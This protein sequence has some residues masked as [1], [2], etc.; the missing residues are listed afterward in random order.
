[1]VPPSSEVAI[2]LEE[3]QC[4]VN[5]AGDDAEALAREISRLKQ[6]TGLVERMG[7]NARA[8]LLRRFTL[9]H[10]AEQFYTLFNEVLAKA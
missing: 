1:M 4:C 6:D 3:E 10:A 7:Q 8:A 9:H 2:V 5:V